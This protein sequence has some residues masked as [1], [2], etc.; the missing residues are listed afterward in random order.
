[1]YK[2]IFVL[3]GLF[4]KVAMLLFLLLKR[5]IKSVL[6]TKMKLSNIRKTVFLFFS[7]F[8]LNIY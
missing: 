8:Q 6:A 2:R 5:H 1:M 7:Y 3:N 4:Y